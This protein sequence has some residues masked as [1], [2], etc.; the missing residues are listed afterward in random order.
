VVGVT[1]MLPVALGAGDF[2]PGWPGLPA[3]P[4]VLL[5]GESG[6]L[7]YWISGMRKAAHHRCDELTWMAG[8]PDSAA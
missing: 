5:V 7:I 8:P 6:G 3:S 4:P 2:R 1:V